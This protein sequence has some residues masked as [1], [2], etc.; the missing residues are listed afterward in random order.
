VNGT[1]EKQSFVW[2]VKSL[3]APPSLV[4]LTEHLTKVGTKI[5]IFQ[6]LNGRQSNNWKFILKKFDIQWPIT[7]YRQI[8]PQKVQP[9]SDLTLFVNKTFAQHWN[10]QQLYLLLTRRASQDRLK[11][12]V[13]LQFAVCSSQ[14]AVCTSRDPRVFRSFISTSL[15]PSLAMRSKMSVTKEFMTNIALLEIPIS[16]W[17]CLRTL[18]M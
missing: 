8:H 4:L 10:L 18:K 9:F 16:G 3:F 17:T 15:A 6:M 11:V 2:L 5:S 13:G 14:F 1:I 7:S 12:R